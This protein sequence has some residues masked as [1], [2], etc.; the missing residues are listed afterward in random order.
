L[1]DSVGLNNLF[2]LAVEVQVNEGIF[3]SVGIVFEEL[4]NGEQVSELDSVSEL[5][6]ELNLTDV[7][8]KGN[9]NERAEADH[10]VS[11]K[12]GIADRV[13]SSALLALHAFWSLFKING[14]HEHP[15]EAS[16]EENTKVHS[17]H[18]GSL[19]VLTKE[20]IEQ[21]F[22]TDLVEVHDNRPEDSVLTSL[23]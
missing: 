19:L 13:H 8:L 6:G 1:G 15:I 18:S 7:E 9:G 11:N 10:E 4:V 16:A 23:S 12:P 14:D 22:S 17:Y 2:K 5:S 3:V 21:I 20:V